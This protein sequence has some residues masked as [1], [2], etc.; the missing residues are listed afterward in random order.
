M[1]TLPEDGGGGVGGVGGVG[2]VEAAV[3]VR[4]TEAVW[5]RNPLDPVKT[6]VAV[7][8]AA[9]DEAVKLTCCGVPTV[10]V[11]DEGEAVTPDGKPL[12]ATLTTPVKLETAVA[13][14][15]MACAVPPAAMLALAGMACR[16][17]S[18]ELTVTEAHP[19]A[20]SAGNTAQAQR[21]DTC[22]VLLI[23]HCSSSLGVQN[24]DRSCDALP[25]GNVGKAEESGGFEPII[26]RDTADFDEVLPNR[27]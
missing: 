10:S 6:T 26:R 24:G 7:V 16:A 27:E 12:I 9:L 15:V 25:L 4:A 5:V 14:R 18:A 19:P 8:A 23:G 13:V 2:V 11:R 20:H 21:L 1:S 22:Q 17:K 3:T